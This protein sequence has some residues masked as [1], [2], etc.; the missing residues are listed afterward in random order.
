MTLRYVSPDGDQ[1]YPGKLTVQA[2]YTLGND[3]KLTIDYRATTDKPT[4]VN[5]TNHTYWN[6]GGE[7]S[8]SVMDGVLTIPGQEFTPVD[9]TLIRPASSATSPGPTSISARASR[10]ARTSATARSHSCCAATATT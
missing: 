4:I 2:T 10:S 9:P 6:L 1:G 3:N 7:G 8:G 5:I